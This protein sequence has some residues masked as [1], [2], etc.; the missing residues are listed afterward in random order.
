MVV[1]GSA[2]G[3]ATQIVLWWKA[4]ECRGIQYLVTMLAAVYLSPQSDLF[5][6]DPPPI[7]WIVLQSESASS[8]VT[9]PDPPIP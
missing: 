1:P 8:H 7:G 6:V 5:T 3:E 9:W 2:E 4:A